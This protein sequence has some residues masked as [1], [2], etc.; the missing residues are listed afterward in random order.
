MRSETEVEAAVIRWLL[1]RGWDVRH[2]PQ[3]G[4]DL[5]AQRGSEHLVVE[6]KG[7]T[8]APGVD[9]DTL[10]GQILRRIDP[11]AEMTRYAVAVPETL[12]RTIERVDAEVLARLDVDVLLVDD[13][14]RVR[15]LGH[16]T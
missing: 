11:G 15:T 5:L 16:D 1:E 7:H 13:F 14:G 6:A 3:N 9:V 10:I 2:G 4:A 8:S 12:L